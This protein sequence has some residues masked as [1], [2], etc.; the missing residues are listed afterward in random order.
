MKKIKAVLMHETFPGVLL[1]L[2]TLAALAVQN[3]GLSLEYESFLDI[4]LGFKAASIE[5]FKPLILWINDGLIAVFFFMIGLELKYELMRGALKSASAITLPIFAAFGGMV[6]PALIFY[7]FNAH[8]AA[9]LKAW[10]IPTV[11]DIAF[12]VGVILL[13]GSRVPSALKIFLLSLA[14]FDDL[15]AIIIIALF[16]TSSL[17]TLALSVASVCIVAL[18]LLNYA[19]VTK[20]S[21]YVLIAIILWTALLKSGVHATLSGVIVALF[22]PLENKAAKPFL[23]EIEHDLAPWIN[24]LIL[25][26][27][28]FANAGVSFASF[29]VKELFSTLS[30][31]II[32][33]LFLGKQIGV[34]IFSLLAIKLRF[35]KMPTGANLTQLYGVSILTG[36]GFTMGFFINSLAFDNT[37]MNFH[38]D[39]LAILLAS[40][41][42]A[43]V[44]YV[45]LRLACKVK[46]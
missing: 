20:K 22:I 2:A 19:H 28:A 13:L 39:K 29:D 7:A 34:F 10:A 33:G 12:A 45:V 27:F 16:Y 3:L 4:N 46:A 15:G 9:A 14:I 25:P 17:S 8:D 11:T 6:V 38:T 23:K 24:Y 1:I 37:S 41:L 5:V 42:S 21:F 35:A 18:G 30:L 43:V 40:L 26:L 36:I 44:G 31:G 32:A